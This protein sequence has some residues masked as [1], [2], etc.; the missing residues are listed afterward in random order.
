MRAPV[1]TERKRL[2][3]K[4]CG[5][6]WKWILYCLIPGLIIA[7]VL[8]FVSISFL[9]TK[10]QQQRTLNQLR[11]CVG[12]SVSKDMTELVVRKGQC[13]GEKITVLD[14]RVFPQLREMRVGDECFENVKEVKVIG[15]S[16]LESVVVGENSFTKRKNSGGYD[17]N[18]RFYL[19]NCEKLRELKMGRYSF[20][21]YSVFAIEKVDGLEV[22]EIG[23]MEEYSYNFYATP[24]ELK[25]DSKGVE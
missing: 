14:L 19:K 22:M 15:L 21:D 24:L 16:E 7:I 3:R 13:N 1:K 23:E 11:E 12:S 4:W 17:S 5:K 2:R 8:Y 6:N 10:S 25:S 20:S 18:H 9:V